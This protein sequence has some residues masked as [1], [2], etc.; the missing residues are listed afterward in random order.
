VIHEVPQSIAEPRP[1]LD[2]LDYN[3]AS[4]AVASNAVFAKSRARTT[5][6]IAGWVPRHALFG[7]GCSTC[8]AYLRGFCFARGRPP[9]MMGIDILRLLSAFPRWKCG[10]R[11]HL[12]PP[13]T[14][15]DVKNAPFLDCSLFCVHSRL[16]GFHAKR[17]RTRSESG[18]H[19]RLGDLFARIP[20]RKQPL[21]HGE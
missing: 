16:C 15:K 13:T 6:V 21:G 14:L 12:S 10:M 7:G 9:A 8:G 11:F 4:Y 5:V 3:A 2:R 17:F 18:W 1:N 20:A 19:Q